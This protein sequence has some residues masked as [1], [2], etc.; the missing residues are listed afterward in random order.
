[1]FGRKHELAAER[2]AASVEQAGAKADTRPIAGGLPSASSTRLSEQGFVGPAI[3]GV[4]ARNHGSRPIL[5]A[6]RRATMAPNQRNPPDRGLMGG[7][8]RR[9]PAGFRWCKRM[10]DLPRTYRLRCPMRRLT[11]WCSGV[12]NGGLRGRL[13]GRRQ[14]AKKSPE[15]RFAKMDQRRQ[16]TLHRGI[17]RQEEGRRKRRRPKSASA[18]STR[19]ATSRSR[20]RNSDATPKKKAQVTDSGM[21]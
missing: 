5:V 6:V 19:T 15:E 2:A 12:G 1:M 13:L 9:S 10:Q 7:N 17:H 20:S 4:P 11:S 14:A 18:S 3:P 16:E 21:T 8:R